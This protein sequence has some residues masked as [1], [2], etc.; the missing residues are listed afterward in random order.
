VAEPCPTIERLT[1]ALRNRQ[2]S[3]DDAELAAHLMECGACQKQLETLAGGSSWLETKARTHSATGASGSAPLKQAMVALESRGAE[4][5]EVPAVPSLDFLQPSGQ[6]GMLGKFGPYE[7]ISH[8]ASGGM[9][10]VLKARD[11]ALDRIVAL[12]LL[13]PALAANALARAR[14]I[15]EARAAAAVVHEHVVPIY[16][17]DEC[18]GHPYLVMQFVK[19]RALSERIRA[20]GPLRLEE[21]LRIG[22]QTAAGLAAAHAQ[23]LTHRDVK[24]GNI[25]LENS[26][27]RVKL[28]DFGLARAVDEVGL[29]RTGELAGTPEF[30]APEQAANE[31]VDHRADLF[32]FGSVLYAMCTGRSPFQASSVLAAI[33][34]VCDEQ[35]KPVHEINS[36][37]P[38]WLSDIIAKLMAKA[39]AE[40]FQSAQEV[41]EL[42]GRHL[43]RVQHGETDDLSEKSSLRASARHFAIGAAI[44]VVILGLGFFIFRQR[45]IG[46]IRAGTSQLSP[47][48]SPQEPFLVRTE[49]GARVGAFLNI[50]DALAAAPV[51]GVVELNWN[52]EREMAPVTLPPKALTLRAAKGFRPVWIHTSLSASAL[53]ASAA[54]TLEDIELALRPEPDSSPANPRG[55][56]R[57]TRSGNGLI[58]IANAPLRLSRCVLQLPDPRS[59]PRGSPLGAAGLS[60][61]VLDNVGTCDLENSALLGV[62]STWTGILWRQTREQNT[63]VANGKSETRLSLSNCVVTGFRAFSPELSE[64]ARVELHMVRCTFLARHLIDFPPNS[65]GRGLNV[66]A[67][68]NVFATGTIISDARNISRELLTASLH[69]QG[70]G[71]LFSVEAGDQR[72]T[73][74]VVLA[75]SSREARP[76]SLSAW[77]QWWSA[78]EAGS[79]EATVRF[80]G[81]ANAPDSG[82]RANFVRAAYKAPDPWS[83]FGADTANVGP[84]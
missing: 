49:S 24:P 64:K 78:P 13:A 1:G 79:E 48:S 25:L 67:L 9:G 35:P 44:C 4:H 16:A 12:K 22:A 29:T 6:P 73:A 18:A 17:V 69:W 75:P 66:V 34:K 21:I 5:N 82:N 62:S 42:L 8:I 3:D 43:A 63:A 71:N 28:T 36:A 40:R 37:I 61:I 84:R 83:R 14:F 32:S 72:P 20:T 59:Q 77:N 70:R 52:G 45:S 19:G 80:P 56:P 15:R 51:G 26:V 58:A 31:P 50:N 76:D 54:L 74:Y 57:L 33:R 11:P 27:E 41:G 68:T 65:A 55:R 38:R 23:G 53:G 7:V 47:S 2:P 46:P 30:M 10:I 60:V 39:P 81:V